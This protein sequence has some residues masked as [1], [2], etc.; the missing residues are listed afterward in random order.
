MCVCAT[1]TFLCFRKCIVFVFLLFI[2]N[3]YNI[4]DDCLQ[5]D[6]FLTLFR[7]VTNDD[8]ETITLGATSQHFSNDDTF[9]KYL[10]N[11]VNDC[12][13]P[14]QVLANTATK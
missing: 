14:D 12:F 4:N 13:T 5:P 7:N 10:E 6:I 2:L 9:V 8:L 1:I 11:T 3:A